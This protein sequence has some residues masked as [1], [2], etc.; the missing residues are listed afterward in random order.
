MK[1]VK[2]RP[3]VLGV[4]RGT[5]RNPIALPSLG[6]YGTLID[7]ELSAEVMRR[8]NIGAGDMATILYA[9]ARDAE[10]A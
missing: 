8:R 4:L 10:D 2:Y 1:S 9:C 6:K 5:A 7:I 3:P